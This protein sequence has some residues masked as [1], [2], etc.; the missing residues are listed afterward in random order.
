MKRY[1]FLMLSIL[2]ILVAEDNINVDNNTTKV[3]KK[4]IIIDLDEELKN[5]TRGKKNTTIIESSIF[6]GDNDEVSFKGKILLEKAPVLI[7]YGDNDEVA[8]KGDS[9]TISTMELKANSHIIMKDSNGTIFV[10]QI[11]R[12]Y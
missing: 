8:L 5:A 1:L 7:T 2:M 10:D 11:V 12:R 3:N 4:K 6:I 9:F